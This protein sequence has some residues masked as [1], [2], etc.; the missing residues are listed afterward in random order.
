MI[1]FQ[2]KKYLKL[3]VFQNEQYLGC[4]SMIRHS[5]RMPSSAINDKF[6]EW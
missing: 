3:Y 2:L 5:N 6:D 4:W 1:V